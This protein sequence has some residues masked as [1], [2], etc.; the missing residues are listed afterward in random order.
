MGK[1]GVSCTQIPLLALEYEPPRFSH[2]ISNL[3]MNLKAFFSEFRVVNLGKSDSVSPLNCRTKSSKTVEASLRVDALASAGFKISRTKLA[4]LIRYEL[5]LFELSA[6]N[7]LFTYLSKVV[8]FGLSSILM[9]TIPLF[10]CPVLGMFVWI[11]FQ[12]WKMELSSNLE[13][14]FL[15]VEWED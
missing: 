3:W 2:V 8:L 13:M 6:I 5:W 7:F 9:C 12:Y 14:L 4:S 10:A 1:V 11:G 15:S